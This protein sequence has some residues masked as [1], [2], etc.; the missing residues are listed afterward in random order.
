M[1]TISYAA[2]R[3]DAPIAD[4]AHVQGQPNGTRV[5]WFAQ[6]NP[7]SRALDR[8][9]ARVLVVPPD[10]AG[11]LVASR[12]GKLQIA[13]REQTP[14]SLVAVLRSLGLDA[15]PVF[16][17]TPLSKATAVALARQLGQ[18]VY[19]YLHV[20]RLDCAV[21]THTGTGVSRGVVMGLG[22]PR[23]R[24]PVVQLPLT[25]VDETGRVEPRSPLSP[26]LPTT[27]TSLDP[28]W[29]NRSGT[30]PDPAWVNRSGTAHDTTPPAPAPAI[31]ASAVTQA[32]NA[33]PDEQRGLARTLN[34]D[35]AASYRNWLDSL[36]S[37][38]FDAYLDAQIRARATWLITAIQHTSPRL[39]DTLRDLF[40]TTAP[41][42]GK[43]AAAADRISD[44]PDALALLR[45]YYERQTTMPGPDTTQ[46][47]VEDVEGW[48]VGLASPL[49]VDMAMDEQAEAGQSDGPDPMDVD[50]PQALATGSGWQQVDVPG[51]TRWV[52]TDLDT[53][54]NELP[55]GLRRGRASGVGMRCLID[56]LR[57]LLNPLPGH[58]GLT[59]DGL[60]EILRA[61]LPENN[62]AR[63]QLDTNEAV[64]ATLLLADFTDRYQVRVQVFQHVTAPGDPGWVGRP[65]HR[66]R[67]TSCTG[68]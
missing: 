48:P 27:D 46:V 35:L 4:L 49:P 54:V 32:I 53:A 38:P 43:D 51:G 14:A 16:L 41:V 58:A 39:A 47:T 42:T 56:S 21:Y 7:H 30:S 25:R 37:A 59:T 63:G 28:V 11:V 17:P 45:S 8:R 40:T 66:R 64:D 23:H 67:P 18:P 13:G 62:E 5:L 44:S 50:H 6:G 3:Q 65:D 1:V 9:T 22:P 24:P 33:L 15:G 31:P 10:A 68:P 19:T 57:Q 52:R 12:D 26:D 34:I 20:A 60:V 36:S 29:I 61:A 55:P 2:A